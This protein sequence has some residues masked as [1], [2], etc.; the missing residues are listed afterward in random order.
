VTLTVFNTLGV[1]V[2]HLVNKEVGPG[3]HEVRFDGSALAAGVYFYCL[4]A[5]MYVEVKKMIVVK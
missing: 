1:P 3:Y 5:G 2:A 4:N